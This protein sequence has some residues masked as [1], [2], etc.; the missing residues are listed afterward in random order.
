MRE[1]LRT[2]S[3]RK[4]R[5]HLLWLA[6]VAVVLA[7]GVVGTRVIAEWPREQEPHTIGYTELLLAMQSGTVDSIRVRPGAEIRGWAT[8]ANAVGAAHPF[9]VVYST[10]DVSSLLAAA[11]AAHVAVSFDAEP[12]DYHAFI[13]TLISV[14]FLVLVGLLVRRQF[15]GGVDTQAGERG[16]S[17][18]T[19]NDVAGNA[20]ALTDLREIVSFLK[21]PERFAAMGAR[22]PKGVLLEGPPGTGKTLMARALAGEAGVPCFTAS[23]SD[24]TGIFVGQGVVRI[25]GLFKKARK[26][27]G[28]VIFIDELDSLGGRRGRQQGHGEDDRTLNQFLV[29]LDGFD[30]THGIV[31]VGATNRANELDPAL[32]RKGRFDRSVTVSLPTVAER[33]AILA[34]HVRERRVPLDA[35]VDLGRLARLMPGASGAEL[36]GLVNE[37]AIT[38]VRAGHDVVTWPHVEEA[39]DRV[40]LGRAREGFVVSDEERRLVAMH[41]A[42]HALIGVL[43][44]P[45]DPLHKVTIQPRGGAMGVAFFQPDHE[46]HLSSRDYLEA[47][48]LKALAGRAAEELCFGAAKITSGAASDLQHATRVAK[49]MVYRLGMGPGTGLMIY[50]PD[51]GPVSGEMHA[52]MDQDV[53]CLLDELYGRVRELLISNRAALEALAHGLL[54][55]ETLSGAEAIRILDAAG[56]QREP[57]VA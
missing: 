41:E 18:L 57:L 23:G 30:P 9:R 39:R 46:A 40:L 49:Q 5:P 22:I 44:C 27:G 50:D 34:L 33:E 52:K 51:S 25:K 56:F 12:E 53:R 42:G 26:A 36:A 55:H 21:E 28:A 19:F 38:A 14:A 32:L 7:V 13:G 47:Q 24:F 4:R 2:T 54:A 16:T 45:R 15:T 48:I 37:A 29:E 3:Q 43:C 6:A 11:T 8:D 10:A 20:A 31:V 17:N 1:T 35:A